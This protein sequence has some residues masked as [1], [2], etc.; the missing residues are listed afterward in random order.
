MS[1]RGV[2][3]QTINIVVT[4]M[5]G[6]AL[7]MALFAHGV[8]LHWINEPLL[9]LIVGVL[10]GP[11]VLGW[12]DLARYGEETAIIEVVARFT[13]VMTL[14]IVGTELRG[15]LPRHW[16]SITV[17]VFGGLLLMWV[18]SS[19]LVRSILGFGLLPAL[20]IGAVLS[21][22]DPILT[23]TVSTG[24]I[25]RETLPERTRHLL[26]AESAARHG[27]G[28]LPVLLLALLIR[29][30]DAEAWRHWVTD[31]L[32]WKGG[33][34]ALA[35]AAAGYA[36]ARAQR[37]STARGYAEIANGPFITLFLAL[38]LSLSSLVELLKSDGAVAVLVAGVVFALAC[39]GPE[40]GK[41]IEGHLQDYKHLLK[42]VLQV[43]IFVLLG[44][45]L[46]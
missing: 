25:A 34:A 2:Q 43:P 6:L 29:E 36:V 46:P 12:L 24:R 42:Q 7:L 39:T 13:L 1:S 17:L 23:T 21:P 28:L 26:S 45:A 32:L 38:A 41:E 18:F 10:I 35:G 15:Y 11:A 40:P 8:R 22:T 3:M 27:L 20:L 14:V 31:V 33:F 44:T 4:C 5:A 30:P 16:R 37:W 9:G 19:L